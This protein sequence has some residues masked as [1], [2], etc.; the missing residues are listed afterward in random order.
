MHLRRRLVLVSGLTAAGKTTHS[1]LLAGRLGWRYLGSSELLRRLLPSKIVT[2]REWDPAFDTRRHETPNIDYTLDNQIQAIMDESSRPLV[3][4]AW[5]QPWLCQR[6][7]AVRV[8][9]E[10]DFPSRQMKARV[11]FMRE[12]LAP[13][14]NLNSQIEDKDNFSRTVFKRLYDISFGPDPDLFDV[15]LDNSRFIREASITASDRG[16]AAF[17]QD[18][19][20]TIAAHLE[21]DKR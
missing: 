5:L 4:D 1:T 3:V 9:L 20:Q 13:P 8:W 18:F 10:S 16:I 7:D 17:R 12:N 19:E 14:A 21:Q 6:T 11:S 2:N 15:I